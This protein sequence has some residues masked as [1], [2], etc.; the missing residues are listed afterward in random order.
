MKEVYIE[1][2]SLP[3]AYH[4]AL[5][6]LSNSGDIVDCPDYDQMQ[7][8]CMMTVRVENPMLEPRI[9]K[10][11]ICGPKEL[12]Q[13]EMEI[14]DGILDFVIGKAD[15]LW[16]Y[17][18]HERYAYQLDF[19]ISEL[20]REP[21]SRRAIM[22]TRN[23]E[24]DSKNDHPACLQS[25]QYFIREEKLHCCV[26][27]RSNDLPEAFF[28]NAFALIKLQEKVAKE[29]GVEMG[30]YTHR[31]N[32]MHAYEKNFDLLEGYVSKI[33][34]ADEEDLLYEYEGFFQDMMEEYDDEIFEMI[35]AKR[36]K[37]IND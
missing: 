26:L 5:K 7:K 10:L 4:K 34:T 6:A 9:S 2:S 11:L 12:R 28:M 25:I 3:N 19:I 20:K 33:E 29:L 23:F 15:N 31:S 35:E 24:T 37:Y 17:T 27:F 1:G 32:S 14:I 36:E 16:E 8:E 21:Y 22:S 18:Y 13:Y 30:S